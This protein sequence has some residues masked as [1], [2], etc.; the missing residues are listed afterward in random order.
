MGARVRGDLRSRP[1][2]GGPTTSSQPSL[3][4]EKRGRAGPGTTL[5]RAGRDAL[6]VISGANHS[7]R[8]R[9]R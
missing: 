5:I 8:A 7:T 1:P 6:E 4:R 9:Q 2:R 3:T